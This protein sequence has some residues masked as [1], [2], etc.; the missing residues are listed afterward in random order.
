MA[1][2]SPHV[3][4]RW[5]A[6]TYSTG[7][8]TIADWIAM[9]E[10]W[11]IPAPQINFAEYKASAWLAWLVRRKDEPNLAFEDVS[12]VTTASLYDAASAKESSGVPPTDGSPPPK[13]K[14][15]RSG[16]RSTRASTES[17]HGSSPA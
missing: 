15:G 5:G 7:D 8:L 1:E 2:Q 16:S 9:E 11:G 6:E 10:E 3:M 4:V 13:R 17:A 14:P 12:Q